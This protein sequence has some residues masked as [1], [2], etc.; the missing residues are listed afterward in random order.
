MLNDDEHPRKR[1]ERLGPGSFLPPLDPYGASTRAAKR[2]TA[3]SPEAEGVYIVDRAGQA[4]PR[5]LRGPL[6]RE[7]RLWPHQDRR[8]HRGAGGG[9]ALLS[10][11]CRSRLRALDPPRQ[12]DHRPR[13]ERHEPRVLRAV[14]F[15]RERDQSQARLVHQQRARTSREEEDHLALARLSRLRPD[16]R[17]PHRARR[18][19]QPVRPAAPADPAHGSALLF[20]SPGPQH[21]RG[22]VLAIS[23]PTS[24]TR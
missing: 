14:R 1:T 16:E 24:S 3:S 23:A 4:Q 6:L 9:A 10:C 11:L 8:R 17:Q 22:A 21:E 18:L 2:R 19:P 5:C 12:D 7:C 15:G 13:A 20:P